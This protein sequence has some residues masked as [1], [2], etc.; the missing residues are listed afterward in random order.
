MPRRH[1]MRGLYKLKELNVQNI[2][3]LLILIIHS[4]LFLMRFILFL[5]AT[6][7]FTACQT[8]TF[9]ADIDRQKI[10]MDSL[11]A[12]PDT[13]IEN[14]IAPYKKQI[15]ASMN[16]VIGEVAQSLTKARPESLL[17]NWTADAL[18][19]QCEIYYQQPIDFTFTNYGGLRIP[20]LNKGAVTIG[21]I[22]EL[23]PFDN[24][25]VVV[26]L[27]YNEL[28]QLLTHFA[29]KGGEPVSHQLRMRINDGQPSEI[30][31]NGQPLDANRTYKVALTDYIANGGDG[32]SFLRTV[33][34]V[35]LQKYFRDALIEYVKNQTAE[36]KVIDAALDGRM[37]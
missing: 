19:I 32:L 17:G 3:T 4:Q 2:K 7:A 24:M 26:E 11:A 5:A 27:K 37:R 14:L 31:L 10:P 29:K 34:Q 30:S 35:H 36:G 1:S 9:L 8:H 6:F 21:G 25:M 28:M 16:I 22:F 23:M 33:P 20:A 18:H 12:T 15:D 13:A